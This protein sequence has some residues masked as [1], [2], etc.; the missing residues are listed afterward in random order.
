MFIVQ[1]FVNR[2]YIF[3]LKLLH[4]HDMSFLQCQSTT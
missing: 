1:F 4:E 3:A 2:T